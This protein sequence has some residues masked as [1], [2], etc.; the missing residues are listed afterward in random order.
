MDEMGA[1]D[2]GM[3]ETG[4]SEDADGEEETAGVELDTDADGA[5]DAP[6]TASFPSS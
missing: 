2:A 3:E 5:L 6:A 1:C 4:V